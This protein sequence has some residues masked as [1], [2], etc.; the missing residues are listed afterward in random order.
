MT[1]F[2]VARTRGRVLEEE[3]K[4]TVTLNFI[5]VK[6]GPKDNLVTFVF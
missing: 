6:T 1:L 2:F 4:S 3:A 5:K